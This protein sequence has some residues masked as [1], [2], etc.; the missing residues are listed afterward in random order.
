MIKGREQLNQET[1]FESPPL[2]LSSA[3]TQV[4]VS[5]LKAGWVSGGR[6]NDGRIQGMTSF[7]AIHGL[8]CF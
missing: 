2:S 6:K 5:T 7:I 8:P 3:Y 1:Q 4:S